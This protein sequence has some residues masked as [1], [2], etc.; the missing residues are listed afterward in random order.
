MFLL[1]GELLEMKPGVG[2]LFWIS[3]EI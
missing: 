3:C 1:Y 2:H